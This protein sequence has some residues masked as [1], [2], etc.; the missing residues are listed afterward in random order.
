MF[1]RSLFR[2]FN[3]RALF[4]PTAVLV[5]MRTFKATTK[6]NERINEKLKNKLNKLYHHNTP[7]SKDVNE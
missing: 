6:E 4:L 2:Q 5:G 1:F 3:P 7:L